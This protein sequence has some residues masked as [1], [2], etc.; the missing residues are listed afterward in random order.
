M[1]IFQIVSYIILSIGTGYV[2][3]DAGSK[4]AETSEIPKPQN[5]IECGSMNYPSDNELEKHEKTLFSYL[6]NWC[7]PDT[8]V[9]QEV[10]KPEVEEFI[11]EIVEDT[12]DSSDQV[13]EFE[14]VDYIE[15]REVFVGDN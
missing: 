1:K 12:S 14:H 11:F 4:F 15:T 2:V 9:Q 3:F 7:E 13:F 5:Y 6:Q 8:V 10:A